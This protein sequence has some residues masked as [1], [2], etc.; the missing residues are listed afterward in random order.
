MDVNNIYNL[1]RLSSVNTTEGGASITYGSDFTFFDKSKSRETFNLKLANNL[2]L[3][4]NKDLPVNNKLVKKH[5]IFWRNL[6]QLAK[7]LQQNIMHQLRI[8]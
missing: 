5:L 6:L 2:R 8:I 3:E 1:D 7:F 4:E